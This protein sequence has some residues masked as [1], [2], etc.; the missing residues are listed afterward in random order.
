MKKLFI[1]MLGIFLLSST[2]YAQTQT[3]PRNGV[4]D[5][6]TDLYAFT[7]ATII[8]DAN[9]TIEGATLIIKGSVIESIGKGINIPLGAT[10]VDLKGKK[11][12]PS[13]VE[14]YSN[15]GVPEPKREGAG[16]FR[17]DPQFESKKKGAYNWNQAILPETDAGSQF[18]VNATA[19]DELRKIGF[20][21]AVTHVQDGIV[22][23]TSALVALMDGR[24]QE[25]MLKNKVSS[26]FSF[27]KGTST[28]DNPNSAM[29]VVALLRQTYLDADWYKKTNGKSEF[30]ISLDAFNSNQ[31]M[32][33]VFEA[34]DKFGVLRANK[35]TKEFGIQYVMKGGGDEYQRLDEIKAS[36]VSLILP[37]NYPVTDRKSVV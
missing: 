8:Q 30:N 16:G 21:S 2:I 19:A 34:N 13:F 15:Y 18:A 25:A 17:G 4:Q 6:R 29:G 1:T 24:D 20:G 12:Y 3:F 31:S 37:I 33:Q 36:G 10:V 9:T 22:R 5:E 14:S 27:S 11:I 23:G 7:N 35:I 26:H 32:P 28:Q